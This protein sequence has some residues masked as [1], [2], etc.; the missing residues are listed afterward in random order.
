MYFT[1]CV[2]DND[3]RLRVMAG[4]IECAAKRLFGMPDFKLYALADGLRS[5]FTRHPVPPTRPK[6]SPS[7]PQMTF[8]SQ[9]MT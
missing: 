7:D 1:A 8:F 5:I 6:P 2:L 9:L 3:S 4:H